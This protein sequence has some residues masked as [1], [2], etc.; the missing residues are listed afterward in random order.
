[1]RQSSCGVPL[2]KAYSKKGGGDGSWGTGQ[3]LLASDTTKAQGIGTVRGQLLKMSGG[4]P[5][6]LVAG[7][8]GLGLWIAKDDRGTEWQVFNI[9]AAYNK[10]QG[11][12]DQRFSADYAGITNASG[13]I[14][15]GTATCSAEGTGYVELVEAEPG[16]LLIMFD[17]FPFA[18]MMEGNCT[19]A[20]PTPGCAAP[21]HGGPPGQTSRGRCCHLDAP[22]YILYG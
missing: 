21:N 3:P 2:V 20:P 16:V 10:L 14:V 4:G 19:S 6:V 18:P 13:V 9:A 12:T 11:D 5:L 7:R 22:H 1:M 15:N 17:R 8:P